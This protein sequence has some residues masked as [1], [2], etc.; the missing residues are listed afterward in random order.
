MFKAN[1]KNLLKS[2]DTCFPILFMAA[3]IPFGTSIGNLSIIFGFIYSLYILYKNKYRKFSFGSFTFLFPVLFFSIILISALTSNNIKA[4]LK[5]V[6]K[7]ILMVLIV[8]SIFVLT[9]FKNNILPKAL[10]VFSISTVIA[11]S[12]LIIFG[13]ASVILGISTNLLF[14]HDFSAL[15][16]QHPVYFALYLS[17]SA[18][19][20]TQHYFGQSKIPFNNKALLPLTSIMIIMCGIIMTASKVVIFVF[21]IIYLFQL[22]LII[23]NIRVKII[24][25]LL[26]LF[27]VL[28]TINVPIIKSRFSDGMKFN[29][30]K[31]E[32]TNDISQARVLTR[33]DKENL[34]DLELRYIFNK[35]GVYH[36]INDEK[37]LFGYGIGDVQDYLDYYYLIY[38]L[39]PNW[40]EGYNL[41]NQYLQIFAS[42]GVFVLIFFLS[43]IVYSFYKAIRNKDYVFLFYLL[44]TTS[45]FIFES[46]L[47]RNKGIVFF[48]FFNTL[49]LINLK[50]NENSSSGN[51]R[52]T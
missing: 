34:S 26:A 22:I 42:Y 37:I 16:D 3:A 18:F 41:H 47:S 51:T 49:F 33:L 17:L 31:F 52:S 36:T 10:K 5:Q 43:Y 1:I 28:I 13:F 7:S 27:T 23:K 38:G 20:I 40:Y 39:A 19:F 48:I 24:A 32:P 30:E 8:I 2:N 15:Y 9:N 6:D 46:L 35:I 11:T 12:I 14:F 44:I 45:V 29:L 4:G 25:L 21:F 50:E